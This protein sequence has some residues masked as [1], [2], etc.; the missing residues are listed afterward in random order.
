MQNKE[1]NVQKI[2]ENLS[3][4]SSILRKLRLRQKKWFLIKQN[5][6][7]QNVTHANMR[8]TNANVIVSEG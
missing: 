2:Y 1:I 6:T 4:I 7:K 5:V 3:L 8:E